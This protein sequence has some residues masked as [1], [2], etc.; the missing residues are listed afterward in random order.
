MVTIKSATVAPD[1]KLASRY[2]NGNILGMSVRWHNAE[3]GLKDKQMGDFIFTM[4]LKTPP[5]SRVT[6]SSS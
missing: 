3:G 6:F 2:A 4:G 1:F 5:L